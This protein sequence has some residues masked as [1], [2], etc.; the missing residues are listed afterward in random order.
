[1]TLN[2]FFEELAKL[3]HQRWRMTG[4]QWWPYVTRKRHFIRNRRGVCPVVAVARALG[5][6]CGRVDAW[7]AAR[8]IGLSDRNCDA[9]I[10][11]ADGY[12]SQH[13]A[14]IKKTLGM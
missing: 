6:R 7:D 11:S 9:I 5:H 14:R 1:M 12:S 10:D 2:Q 8:L 13:T 4:G 3:R